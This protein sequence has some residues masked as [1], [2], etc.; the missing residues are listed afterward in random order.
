MPAL[1]ALMNAGVVP[2][3]PP[4]ALA[5]DSMTIFARDHVEVFLMPDAL[6]PAF[7]HFSFDV[8]GNRYD[9]RGSDATWNACCD[10][11]GG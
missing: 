9:A 2:Q 8:S 6:A 7:Y 3:H 5:P 1:T 4:T 11:G 10:R